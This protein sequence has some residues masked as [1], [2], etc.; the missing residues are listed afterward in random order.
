M[1][2]IQYTVRDIPPELDQALRK[3]MREEGRS[4]NTVL[5][6]TLTRGSGMGAHPII[7]HDFDDLAGKWV[8]D[9]AC[10]GALE[11]LRASIDPDL[12]R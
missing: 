3:R 8:H 11:D 9:E 2:S 1:K 7:N 10:E 5:K 6:E 4:L 12:W